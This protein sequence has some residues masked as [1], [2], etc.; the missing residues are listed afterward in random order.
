MGFAII[1]GGV[2]CC[3]FMTFC[4]TINVKTLRYIDQIHAHDV[5]RQGV[6][7]CKHVACG[8]NT[9]CSV[10]FATLH[11]EI[12]LLQSTNALATSTPS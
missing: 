10:A 3:L 4:T 1:T 11:N 7:V 9:G 5:G 2:M 6:S 8:P 12:F